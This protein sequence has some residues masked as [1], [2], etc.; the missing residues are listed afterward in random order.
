VICA[1]Q[2]VPLVD[3][4]EDGFLEDVEHAESGVPVKLEGRTGTNTSSPSFACLGIRAAAS[5]VWRYSA[6]ADVIVVE[7]KLVDGL[8]CPFFIRNPDEISRPG[9][10]VKRCEGEGK[11]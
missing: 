2:A 4:G 6:N 5:S 10:C 9:E 1:R 7:A 11:R 3:A 8:A